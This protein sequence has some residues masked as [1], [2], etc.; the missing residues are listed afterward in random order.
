MVIHFVV[1]T[2]V[3]LERKLTIK[4]LTHDARNLLEEKKL[5]LN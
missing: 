1:L 3:I 5:S 4:M 2:V